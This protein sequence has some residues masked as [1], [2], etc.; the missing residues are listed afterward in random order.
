MKLRGLWQLAWSEFKLNLRNPAMVFWSIAFPALWMSLFGAIAS[1]PIPGFEYEGLNLANFLLPGGI[2]LVIVAS[3]FIGTPINL[4][5]YREAGVL[6]RLRV[7]PLRTSTLAFGFTLSQFIFMVLG[8]LVLFIIGKIF[9]N[10]QVLGSWAALIGM[11]VFRMIT[12]L[13]LG[14]AIG[15]VVGSWRT[16]AVVTQI[17]FLPMLFLSDLFMPISMFPD[18]L[19]PICKVLPL[20]PLNIFLRDIVYGVPLEGLWRLVIMTGWLVLGSVITLKFFKWE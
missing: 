7:T 10:V 6:K 17:F 13:V 20:T 14:S 11:I 16:A 8:I 5:T 18:W 19:Q 15:S 2:G 3:A 4:T 1:E 12:F 9:F